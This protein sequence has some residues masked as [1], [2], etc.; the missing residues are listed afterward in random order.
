MMPMQ[1]S[2][3]EAKKDYVKVIE[4]TLINITFKL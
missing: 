4:I 1:C 3:F 2:V